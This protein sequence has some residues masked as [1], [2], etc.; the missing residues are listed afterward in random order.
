MRRNVLLFASVSGFMAVALGAFGAHGLKPLLTAD[1]LAAY[2]TGVRYQFYH[3]LV[4]LFL[5]SADKNDSL[6]SKAALF[7][8]AG[9]ILFSGSLYAMALTSVAGNIWSWLGPVTPLG[10]LCLLIGWVMLFLFTWKKV[11]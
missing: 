3:T 1:M 9:I 5:A 6:I 10:G 2:E 7:F 11:K 8:G 4:L